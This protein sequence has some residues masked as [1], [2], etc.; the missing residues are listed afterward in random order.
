MLLT[1]RTDGVMKMEVFLIECFTVD[2]SDKHK[3]DKVW[4]GEGLFRQELVILV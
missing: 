2:I 1:M 4:F 3:S